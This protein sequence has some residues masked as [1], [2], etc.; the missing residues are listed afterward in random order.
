MT[1]QRSRNRFSES[2]S[3]NGMPGPICL[4]SSFTF[5]LLVFAAYLTYALIVHLYLPAAISPPHHPLLQE[6][7]RQNA[8]KIRA[9]S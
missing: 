3:E 7:E 9:C 8:C 4:T 2:G 6:T 5:V 1:S